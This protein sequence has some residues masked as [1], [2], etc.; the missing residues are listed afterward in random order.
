MKNIQSVFILFWILFNPFCLFSKSVSPLDYGYL[1]ARNGEERFRVL[2]RMHSD[3][4]INNW[5]IDYS[6]LNVISLEIPDDAKSIPLNE[7][8]DFKGV[9]FKVKNL[10]KDFCL[11]S[12]SSS[13][14]KIHLQKEMMDKK[15]LRGYSVFS[16]KIVMLCLEDQN[17]WTK[18]VGYTEK[19]IR[20]DIL[21]F[22]NGQTEHS[23]ISTYGNV[24]SDPVA[25]IVSVT[26]SDK[27]IKNIVLTRDS[28]STKKT[29]L[30]DINNQYDLLLENITVNT[31]R[32]A[33]SADHAISIKN[34]IK[35]LFK[36]IY[37]NG[38]YS[39]Q[40]RYGYGIYLNNV[41]DIT[42]DHLK[43]TG[44][45]GVF[46]SYNVSTVVL[47]KC[48][49]N[50]FD[51][52][53]YVKD[54]IFEDCQIRELYNQFSSF[55][56]TLIFR[57]CLF[58]KSIPVLIESSYNAYTPFDIVL[59][60]CTMNV[61]REHNFLISAGRLDAGKNERFELK[62]KSWPNIFIKNLKI[63]VPKDVS[64]IYLFKV[65]NAPCTDYISSSCTIEIDG[66]Q[67]QSKKKNE[68]IKFLFCNQNVTM[69]PLT[70]CR[71]KSN[72]PKNRV[73]LNMKQL[74]RTDY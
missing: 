65:R 67:I 44:S 69:A 37:I 62:T 71:I 57:R 43:A 1:R 29:F 38:T 22:D 63:N 36:D 18:R 3:A 58:D 7:K 28:K 55:F 23:V 2:Y 50:R 42:F 51:V 32:S 59:E 48:D 19:V 66:M 68:K 54:V 74:Y 24:Y 15:D 34:S 4:K 40:N 53:C 73:S 6:G 72:L 60:D 5:D 41:R 49:I 25:E 30:F 12:M 27:Y 20:K 8:T 9:T 47:R 13:S 39:Q 52:H 31:P 56:G 11:F 10:R 46:G 33:L 70:S 26:K 35:I 16:N 45:W 14:I 61:T 21:L 64:E 17:Q